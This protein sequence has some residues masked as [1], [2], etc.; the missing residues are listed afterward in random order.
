MVSL[1]PA[2]KQRDDGVEYPVPI[3]DM[4]ASVKPKYGVFSH[5]K[6]RVD[7]SES[8]C[9]LRKGLHRVGR[10]YFDPTQANVAVISNA[11]TLDDL[12]DLDL[13]VHQL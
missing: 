10:E 2:V 7:P 4:D 1:D 12:K 6:F 5:I 13:D 11:A 3:F 8:N 9:E